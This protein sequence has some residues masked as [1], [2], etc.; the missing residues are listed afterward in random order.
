[1]Y[2]RELVAELV[3]TAVRHRVHVISDEIFATCVF[4]GEMISVLDFCNSDLHRQY[5]HVVTGLSKLGWS[6]AKIGFAYTEHPELIRALRAV[7]RL[8]PIGNAPTLLLLAP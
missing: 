1:M 2:S 8:T 6:G 3:E 5:V 4:A 7:S